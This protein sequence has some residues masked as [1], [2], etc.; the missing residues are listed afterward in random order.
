MKIKINKSNFKP[1][2]EFTGQAV[3][4]DVTPLRKQPSQYGEQEVFKIVFEADLIGEQGSP[5]CVWSR[6]FTPTLNE[7]SNLRKFLRAWNGRD[8]TK[9]ELQNFDTETL[10]GR[11]AH[12]VV[13]HEHKGDD[14]YA[15]IAACTPEKSDEPLK[16]SGKFVRAKDRPPKDGNGSGYHRA[17]QPT[18]AASEHAAVKIHVGRCKGLELRDLAPEQ[19]FALIEKWLPVVKNNPNPS[20]DDIR[21][22][23]ALEWWA[24]EQDGMCDDVPF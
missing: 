16:P 10:I 24:D 2:P 22:I 12:I 9:Q 8:L 19:V 13:I 11:P 5:C 4:V 3:C 18:E 1:C 15:N 21:L 14:V 7:K 20:A 17:E 6:N 23:A